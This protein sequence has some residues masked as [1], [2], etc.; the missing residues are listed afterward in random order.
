MPEPS[1]ASPLRRTRA[2][3]LVVVVAAQFA[4]ASIVGA[5][6]GIIGPPADVGRAILIVDAPPIPVETIDIPRSKPE[7]AGS[8]AGRF[9]IS[10][11]GYGAG[12]AGGTYAAAAYVLWLAGCGLATPVAGGLAAR[13]AERA[14]DVRSS[15]MVVADAVA[16][17]RMKDDLRLAMEQSANAFAPGRLVVSP[18]AGAVD[19]E[20]RLVVSRIVL[21][22]DGT[23]DGAVRF[24]FTVDAT[25]VRRRDGATIK[26]TRI[27]SESEARRL[28][29]WATDGGRLV[30]AA[31]AR[32]LPRVA[33]AVTDF[34]F[35]LYPFPYV[36]QPHAAT[37]FTGL[38]ADYPARAGDFFDPFWAT[39]EGARPTFRWGAFPRDVDVMAD[40]TTMKRLSN[41]AYD[42]VIAEE[43][44]GGAGPIVYRRRALPSNVHE[45]EKGLSPG[46][47]YF[48]T[49]RARFELD[50][51]A[52]VTEWAERGA[53]PLAAPTRARQGFVVPSHLGYPFKTK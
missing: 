6:S 53:L 52:F 29:D 16:L 49:V 24:G 48:W 45:L 38:Q 40:P 42:L 9:F 22:G 13:S 37:W 33:E 11:A 41:V 8:E 39:A 25:V 15:T 21:S 4:C 1:L 51:R 10:C 5:P 30:N 2:M 12:G 23:P 28:R 34:T 20:L 27:S 7:A 44:S 18:D 46:K 26:S 32:A 35:L 14:D 47:R 31:V 43:E 3:F 50:G 36:G 17:D 19:S